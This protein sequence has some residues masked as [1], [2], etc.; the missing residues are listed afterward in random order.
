MKGEFF[1]KAKN[2]G[3]KTLNY[4]LR[5]SDLHYIDV[6]P[7]DSAELCNVSGFIQTSEIWIFT[8]KWKCAFKGS[9]SSLSCA[10]VIQQ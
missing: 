3:L 7:G 4:G 6:Y 9:D 10:G 1:L 2:R 8:K 5:T